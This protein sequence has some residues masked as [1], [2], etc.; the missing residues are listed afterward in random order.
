MVC[1]IHSTSTEQKMSQHQ[2][3]SGIRQTFSPILFI[4][5]SGRR[6]ISYCRGSGV[7]RPRLRRLRLRRRARGV[8]DLKN[9]VITFFYILSQAQ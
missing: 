8:S 9:Y 7:C 6:P 3:G 4:S 5:L 1:V 2:V